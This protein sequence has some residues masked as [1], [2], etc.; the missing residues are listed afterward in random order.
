MT[1]DTLVRHLR[2]VLPAPFEVFEPHENGEIEV[3]TGIWADDGSGIKVAIEFADGRVSVTETGFDTVRRFAWRELPIGEDT[4]RGVAEIALRYGALVDG[5]NLRIAVI[6]FDD[7][8]K[9]I[10]RMA[11][12]LLEVT[13]LGSIEVQWAISATAAAD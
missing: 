5:T 8:Q 13:R 11:S 7:V 1:P 10:K 3:F 6:D 2:A 4:K 12:L 9:A